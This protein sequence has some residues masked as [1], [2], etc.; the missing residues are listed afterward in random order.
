MYRLISICIFLLLM[1]ISAFA[2]KVTYSEVDR[3][4]GRDM[5]FEIIGKMNDHF[6]VYKN[7]RW[8]NYLTIYDNE[9]QTKEKIK[10]SF[11]PEKTINV[12]FIT[13]PDFFYMIYQY[14]KKGI[15]YCAGVKMDGNGNKLTEPVTIDTTSIGVFAD[16]QIYTTIYSEDKKRIMVFKIRKKNDL[17]TITS[18]LFDD[19]LSSIKKNKQSYSYDDNKDIYDNFLVDNEGTFL[20]T[21]GNKKSNRDDIN[22]LELYIQPAESDTARHYKLPLNDKYI[23]EV[24]VKIDN[25]NKKYIV[26]SFYYKQKRGSI[27][28]LYSAIWDNKNE[29]VAAYNFIPFND[30]LRVAAK[31]TD[32]TRFA[33][34]NYFIRQI[35]V[36]KDGG[37]LLV[38]E[39][40]STQ[41]RGSSAFNRY[42]FFNRYPF[43]SPMDYYRYYPSSLWFYRP[44]N[45]FGNTQNIRYFYDNIMILS[46]NNNVSTE[47]ANVIP[48]EQYDDDN[49][50][51]LSFST[52]NTGAEIR[53]LFNSDNKNQIVADQSVTPTGEIIRN[54]TLKSMEKGYQFMPKFSKQ[55]GYKQLIMPCTYRGSVCFARVDLK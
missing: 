48:K 50:N 18:T 21:K 4:D 54:A 23:D 44:W 55:V 29:A 52:L 2:Q 45:S 36:K 46:I 17:L 13:Y 15:V 34:N 1:N 28:G 39:S 25:L 32:Q 3:Q 43:I 24:H 19:K 14:Q 9:M 10:L 27:E 49:D 30:T 22:E 20:F 5:N 41:S 11:M 51:Y 53:F 16:N 42:D 7:I 33:F 38:A 26:N 47:W 31:G 6:L 8:K 37:F 35:I 12:D 40:Y